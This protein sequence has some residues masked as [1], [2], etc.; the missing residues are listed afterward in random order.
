MK[1]F[2]KYL[3]NVYIVIDS[4]IGIHHNSY[5]RIAGFLYASIGTCVRVCVVIILNKATNKTKKERNEQRNRESRETV[6]SYHSSNAYN[7]LGN[8][9]LILSE[10]HLCCV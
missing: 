2:A 3:R 7:D 5:I 8:D 4:Y 6:K 9:K 10:L 1:W